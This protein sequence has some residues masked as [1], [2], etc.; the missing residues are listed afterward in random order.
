MRTLGVGVIGCGGISG[1]YL[2]NMARKFSVLNVVGVSDIIPERSRAK[3]EEFGIRQM[4]NREICESPEI[5]IV[6]N[7]TFPMAHYQVSREAL[8]AGKHVYSEKMMAVTMDEAN[9]LAKLAE[10]KGLRFAAAPDTF[11]GGGLQTCRRL[12]DAGLIG[13]PVMAQ[14]LIARGS[15]IVTPLDANK[16][17][18]LSPGGGIPFDMGGYYLAALANMLGPVKRAS[19]FAQL[20]NRRFLNVKSPRFM[21]EVTLET[22][23]NLAG[24]LEFESGALATVAMES[25]SFL[26]TPRLELYG[27]EGT[28]ICPDPNTFGGPVRIIRRNHKSLEPCE[29]P[30]THGYWEGCNRGL[31]V[32]DL[33]WAILNGRPHRVSLGYHVFEIIHGIW[34]SGDSGQAYE[35]VSRPERPAALAS[36]YTDAVLME[37][38]LA[39]EPEGF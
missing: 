19:G 33:A 17:M 26:E 13:E 10:E 5:D 2:A 18:T 39:L 3:A 16:R 7:L 27:T 30:L 36:G 35:M 12:V 22:P 11:L 31:G 4:T 9:A 37:T 14:A 1:R 38:A 29:F 28:L 6:V 34:S 24:A 21:D 25:E 32:A 20:R 15:L 8:L 23:T